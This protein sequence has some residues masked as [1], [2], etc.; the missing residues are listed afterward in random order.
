MLCQNKVVPNSTYIKLKTNPKN[1]QN[2]WRRL[3]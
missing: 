3:P 2:L 1:M